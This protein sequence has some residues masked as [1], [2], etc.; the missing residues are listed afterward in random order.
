M[1]ART[2]EKTNTINNLYIHFINEMRLAND[3]EEIAII[4]KILNSLREAVQ[5][6]ADLGSL[7]LE[8]E[9]EKEE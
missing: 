2:A 6:C 3:V 9:L 1:Y 7:Q 8:K 4:D 5:H